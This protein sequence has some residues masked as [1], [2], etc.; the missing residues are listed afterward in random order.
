MC[1]IAGYVG[2][3]EAAPILIEMMRKEEAFAGG[4][5]T[6]LATLYEGRIYHEKLT[7]DL[8]TLLKNTDAKNL[9]G[10]IGIIHSRSK[11][12][13]GDAWSHPFIAKGGSCAYVANGSAGFFKSR[14]PEYTAIADKLIENGYDMA[15]EV[16][17]NKSYPTISNGMSVHM[18]DV[19][20]QLIGSKLDS[21]IPAMQAM[22][23]AFCEMPSEIV[24]LTIDKNV[25]DSIFVA[26]INMPMWIAQA[27]HGT[28]LASTPF[29]FPEDAH[30][31][32]HIPAMSAARVSKNA[33]EIKAFKKPVC[34]VAQITPKVLCKA[35]RVLYE[36][37]NDS[38]MTE[39]E[40]LVRPL[41][42]KADVLQEPS[43]QYEALYQL[44]LEGRLK[45]EI[46]RREGV[47]PGTTA[48]KNYMTVIK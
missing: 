24:G 16:P 29:A 43:L 1:N 26:R 33:Y 41:F 7:G 11:S 39:T 31:F 35:Y 8:D 17:V 13:G 18:S 28:Y 22:E 32:T 9:R 38:N 20:A 45:I 14:I 6:G 5:Y 30:D 19:M 12:G 21:G 40:K 23:Q 27:D 25:P 36:N 37:A 48:P 4:F 42:E 2:S 46:K 10:N 44:H 3:R 47:L 15:L 34:T